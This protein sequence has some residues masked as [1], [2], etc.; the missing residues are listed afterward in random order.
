MEKREGRSVIHKKMALIIPIILVFGIL[1]TVV[2]SVSRRISL[3]MSESAIGN[4]HESLDLIGNT[5]ETILKKEAEF[6]ELI[7]QELVDAED[8]AKFVRSYKRNGTMVKISLIMAGEKSGV[9]NTGEEFSEEELDFSGGK[10]VGDLPVSSS[11][12]NDM[13]TWAYTMKCPV[14]K[15]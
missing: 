11:Y 5:M 14:M 12:V 1:G 9:S 7:A 15:D 8:P 13:G 10:T 2:F 3:E 4:L 6:Q